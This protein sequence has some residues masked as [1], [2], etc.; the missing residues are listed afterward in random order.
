MICFKAQISI[1]TTSTYAGYTGQICLFFGCGLTM[2]CL[3]VNNGWEGVKP[4][5]T[6]HISSQYCARLLT[7]PLAP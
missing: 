7:E 2:T 4:A 5:T 3:S 6:Q 1:I